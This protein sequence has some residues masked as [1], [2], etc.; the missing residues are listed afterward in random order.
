MSLPTISLLM[1]STISEQLTNLLTSEQLTLLLSFT[2]CPHDTG[3]ITSH[4]KRKLTN[5]FPEHELRAS[6]QKRNNWT[7]HIYDSISWTAYLL[8]NSTLT[9]NVRTFVIKLSHAG[10][11]STFGNADSVLRLVSASSAFNPRPYLTCT[12]ATLGQLCV[13]NSSLSLRSTSKTHPLQPMHHCTGHPE[14]V[15]D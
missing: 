5:K 11:Q 9:D 15:P 8:A 6:T 3:Y 14:I 10:Y 12:C 1:Y 13:T 7:D 2:R 4:E